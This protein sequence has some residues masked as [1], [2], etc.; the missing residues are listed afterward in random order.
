M[1]AKGQKQVVLAIALAAIL[2]ATVACGG[3]NDPAAAG[4]GEATPLVGLFGVDPGTCDASGPGGSW[5]RMVQPNGTLADGPFVTNGD[6]SCADKTITPLTPGT[7]GGL[8]TGDFQPQPDPPFDPAGNS[9]SG[10]IAVPQK[11]FAVAFGLATNPTDPQTNGA[12]GAP[13]VTRSGATL[14]GELAALAASWNGQHFNQ[15]APKPGGDRPGL[16][17]GPRGTFDEASRRYTLEWSSQIVGGP[18]SN[19]TGV[20][21]LEGTFQPQSDNQEEQ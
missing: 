10:R 3:E 14:A 7:D 18:F 11:W 8:R 5:F 4:D 19:F 1:T 21:H 6:S 2:F 17:E 12:A 9:M 13:R 20:W 15:G 16:T